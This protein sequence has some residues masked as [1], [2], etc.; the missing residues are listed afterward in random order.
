MPRLQSHRRRL[1]L[2]AGSS[3]TLAG[4]T[5][6]ATL[7]L[8]PA[9]ALAQT[10]TPA[11]VTGSG[12]GADSVSC[13]AGTFPTGITY[14]SEG[15]LTVAMTAN[16]AV[17]ATTVTANGV[18]L[19]GNGTDPVN[20][21]SVIGTLTGGTTTNG[22]VIDVTT[23]SGAI[24]I[25]TAGV[26]G[27]NATITHGIRAASAGGGSIAIVGGSI[28][29]T[30]AASGLT[31]I[32]AVAS[33]G[34]GSV[35]I[36][37][38]NASGRQRG[39]FAQTAGT[40][41]LTI[42]AGSAATSSTTTGGGVGQVAAIEAIT[43]S[44]PLV[45]NVSG[46]VSA[47]FG[48][49]IRTN[50]GGSAAI[51]IGA[52][53]VV[54]A[55]A[56]KSAG[57]FP[58]S[59]WTVD[60]TAASGTT[61]TVDNLGTIRGPSLSVSNFD[62]WVLRGQGAG[63]VVV[64][65]DGL[66]N[67]IV[68]FQGQGGGATLNITDGVTGNPNGTFTAAKGWHTVGTSI[69]SPGAD[70]L[71]TGVEGVIATS[72]AGRVGNVTPGISSTTLDFGGGTDT[73]SNAGYLMSGERELSPFFAQQGASVT[74]L[75]GLES[76]TNSGSIYLG[77]ELP[78]GGPF[79]AGTVADAAIDDVLRMTGGTFTGTGSGRVVFDINSSASQA[80]CTDRDADG[81]LPGADCLDLR[82]VTT[83]G[84]TQLTLND[85][86]P[87]LRGIYNL[88]GLVLVDVAGGSSAQGH[89]VVAPDSDNYDPMF[90]G[91][92]NKGDFFYALVYDPA[93]EKHMLVGLPTGD[94]LQWP[95]MVQAAQGLWRTSTD[96][97]IERQA[98]VRLNP[99]DRGRLWVSVAGEKA[100]RDVDQSYVVL[101]T[102]YAFD[103]SFTQAATSV[104]AGVDL[105]RASQPDFGYLLG[106]TLGYARADVAFD[107]SPNSAEM[108]GFTGGLYGGLT[109]GGLHLDWVVNGLGLTI[110][111][112]LVSLG[113][114]P[115]GTRL[116]TKAEALG[117]RADAGW[118]WW[119]SDTLF[120]EPLAAVSYMTAEFSAQRIGTA[121]DPLF[122]GNE[123]E[124]ETA[125]S[126]RGGLGAKLGMDSDY[127]PV[128]V[129]LS[130]TGRAWEEMEGENRAVLHNLGP[131]YAAI[132][133]FSGRFGEFG[134]AVRLADETGTFSG[135][136]N[137]GSKFQEGYRS[138]TASAGLRYRW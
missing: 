117:G 73:F 81:F 122:P 21:D 30:N 82:D 132:D 65:S 62:A 47:T 72:N 55:S 108:R 19:T 91:V 45:M 89:F 23:G 59:A 105:L 15:A 29:A 74:T 32:E 76:F 100:E 114:L 7:S 68:D 9:A 111:S 84:V 124:F 110:D 130:V 119:V 69:F 60:L 95:L 24:S 129:G 49:A 126:F 6:A 67:G 75:T 113:L 134:G 88:D 107:V 43:A 116:T 46:A 22:P 93:V 34:N 25:T 52:G 8:A 53:S 106:A 28:T 118:R 78:N 61:T 94:T 1:S 99:D 36:T 27:S 35:T 101:G 33:G 63:R 13:L 2:L 103:N 31:A 125:T 12:P 131:D 115:A 58:T 109:A 50:A 138:I 85:L 135:F 5:G 51:N 128:R 64:N 38:T 80:N 86:V 56:G 10:C 79:T 18:T 37:S 16:G 20:W 57:S 70:T 121:G 104:S 39:I 4:L 127:G 41:A 92:L 112:D 87:T 17:V 48:S 123:V 44:G 83:A 77:L 66:I 40:G 14:S 137:A 98:D 71:S 102:T 97:L 26:T 120:V 3:L 96:A 42:N 133:A 136:L 11:T 54:S 90:G